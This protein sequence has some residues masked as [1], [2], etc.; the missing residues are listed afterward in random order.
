MNNA[1]EH[2]ELLMLSIA[3]VISEFRDAWSDTAGNLVSIRVS[4]STPRYHTDCAAVRRT[5]AVQI[6]DSTH[7]S[8][9]RD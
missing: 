9:A 3:N 2:A 5:E 4:Y 8:P 7:P 1:T 6:L